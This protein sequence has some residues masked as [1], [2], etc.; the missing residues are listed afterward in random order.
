MMSQMRRKGYEDMKKDMKTRAPASHTPHLDEGTLR[1]VLE[2]GKIKTGL[3]FNIEEIITAVNSHEALLSLL[4]TCQGF[5]QGL[6]INGHEGAIILHK[7]I[8]Q[9]IIR[10]EGRGLDYEN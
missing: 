10:A 2:A 7:E 4:Y 6:A 9:A 5:T 8:T 1:M 3:Y